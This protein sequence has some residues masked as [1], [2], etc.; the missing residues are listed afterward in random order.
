M[1]TQIFINGIVQHLLND[2]HKRCLDEY[3]PPTPIFDFDENTQTFYI[4]YDKIT[5]I[6]FLK[7]GFYEKRNFNRILWKTIEAAYKTLNKTLYA[8]S[9]G[10]QT[11]N[12]FDNKVN[13]ME[14]QCVSY[15]KNF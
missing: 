13:I 6:P 4:K 14:D 2:Y 11:K 1:D 12:G 8:I 15:S 3:D 10:K 7:G 9:I 5:E